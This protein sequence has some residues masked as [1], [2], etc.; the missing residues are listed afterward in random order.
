MPKKVS[1]NQKKEILDSFY[2]GFSIQQLSEN[3]NFSIPTITKQLKNL[4]GENEF[5]KIKLSIDSKA[6]SLISDNE[7]IDKG[8]LQKKDSLEIN[9]NKQFIDLTLNKSSEFYE[10]PPLTE[11]VNLEKQKDISSIPISEIE[12]PK[13]VYIL[14]DKTIELETKYLKDYPDWQFLSQDELDRKTIE[15]FDD[16]KTAKSFCSKDQKVLK[17]PNPNVFKIVAPILLANGI[18]R[19]VNLDKLISL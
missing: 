12:F 11:G 10:I 17:V 7:I 16:L 8:N 18:S 19:I 15:I 6:K 1:E 13:V 4:I 2:K 9:K 14:V 3:Y 5:K